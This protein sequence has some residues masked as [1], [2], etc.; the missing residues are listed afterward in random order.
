MTFACARSISDIA[1]HAGP[2]IHWLRMYV[3]M[4]V[5]TRRMKAASQCSHAGNVCADEDYVS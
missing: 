2:N 1:R 5:H 3:S 4:Y